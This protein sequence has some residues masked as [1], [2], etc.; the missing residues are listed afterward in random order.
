[1]RSIIV[2]A[3]LLLA[4][5]PDA[6]FPQTLA[7]GA[8]I[9]LSAPQ[10]VNTM[11]VAGSARL[12]TGTLVEM[13]TA[14]LTLRTASGATLTYPIEMIRRLEVSTGPRSAER[15]ATRGVVTGALV[16]GGVMGMIIL[17]PRVTGPRDAEG[18]ST[19]L[20]WKDERVLVTGTILGA[21]VGGI[22]GSTTREGW[23]RIPGYPAWVV[24]DARG[25]AG[26]GLA[27]SF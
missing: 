18:P 5:L 6:A 14:S 4:A 2:L 21:V 8:R 16:G 9:R 20:G 26:L 12:Q 13:D 1:M 22:L 23:V 3:V 15:G 24:L 10:H 25:N 7:P 17:I 27:F 19:I 11:E